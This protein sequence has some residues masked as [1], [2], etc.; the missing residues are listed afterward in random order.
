MA[1]WLKNLPWYQ[2]FSLGH[3][4]LGMKVYLSIYGFFFAVYMDESIQFY[5]CTSSS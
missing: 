3:I 2:S 4:S 5:M 1:A